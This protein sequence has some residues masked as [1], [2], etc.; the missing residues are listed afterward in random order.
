MRSG[1]KFEAFGI[2]FQGL[3]YFILNLSPLLSFRFIFPVTWI[4]MFF[5]LRVRWH[6]IKFRLRVYL[7]RFI[8]YNASVRRCHRFRL[9][10]MR[11]LSSYFT[12]VSLAYY[13]FTNNELKF[14]IQ[15]QMKIFQEIFTTY[16]T[17]FRL[18]IAILY[19]RSTFFVHQNTDQKLAT[20]DTK[21]SISR[22]LYISVRAPNKRWIVTAK[23]IAVHIYASCLLN[24]LFYILLSAYA[25]A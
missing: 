16:T 13:I 14:T 10:L 19:I 12:C 24:T 3:F 1:S 4:C 11:L 18:S 21:I 9:L 25:S 15:S 22:K 20:T 5:S 17:N 2:F 7:G 8:R 23:P 6:R